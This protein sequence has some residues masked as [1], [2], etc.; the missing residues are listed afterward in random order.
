MSPIFLSF[1]RFESLSILSGLSTKAGHCRPCTL[2]IGCVSDNF[3]PNLENNYK[4]AKNKK[5]STWLVLLGVQ[6]IY[7]M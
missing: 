2:N 5:T 6:N 4:R 1:H 7:L 3:N